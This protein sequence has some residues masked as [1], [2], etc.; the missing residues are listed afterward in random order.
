MKSLYSLAAAA[1]LSAHGA[2]LAQDPPD[3]APPVERSRPAPLPNP[4]DLEP[5]VDVG[6]LATGQRVP[7]PSSVAAPPTAPSAPI[8]GN[9]RVI[10]SLDLGTT[11]ITGNQELP[12][13][14]YIVPWK[15]SDIGDLVG[16]P[17]NTL[18]DEVLA[19]IDPEVFERQLNYYESLYGESQEE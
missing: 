13:V 7:R 10:D 8:A 14:L 16:R 11:S 4:A 3:A 18:L 5:A 17:F 9:A 1:L 6:R 15:R 19:P 2:V 12:K